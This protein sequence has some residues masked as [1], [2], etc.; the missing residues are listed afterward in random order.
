MSW[1]VVLFLVSLYCLGMKLAHSQDGNAGTHERWEYVLE[2]T[3]DVLQIA[4]PLSAGL[5]TIFQKDYKGTKQMA[6]SYASTMAITYALKY[7]T[8]R[9][10]PEG[11]NTYDSFPSGH[12]SSAFSGA[13][14]IQRRYGWKYGKYAYILAALVGVS[15][16]EGPDGYHDIWDVLG[17]A[18]VGIG[19]TY[20]FTK[21]YKYQKIE[22]G[23]SARKDMKLLS[24]R[25]NLN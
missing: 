1:R 22:V 18:A 12:T 14:F 3:G 13:S 10:R 11:R 8:K 19:S 16:M 17:G 25:W 24:V 6:F 23:F 20:I 15:R 2:D 21:P 9:Q 7:T 5:A 4:L